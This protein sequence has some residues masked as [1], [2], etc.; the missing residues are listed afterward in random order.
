LN[1]SWK[2]LFYTCPHSRIMFVDRLTACWYMRSNG[3]QWTH[4]REIWYLELLWKSV[5]I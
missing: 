1:E 5:E 4:F 2:E 3:C